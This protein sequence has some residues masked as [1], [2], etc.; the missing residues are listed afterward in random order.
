VVSAA[1]AAV[2]RAGFPRDVPARQGA[3]AR[4]AVPGEAVADLDRGGV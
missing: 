1:C 3:Q 4:R 2:L